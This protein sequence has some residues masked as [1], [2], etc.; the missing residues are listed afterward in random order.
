[1]YVPDFLALGHATRDLAPGGWTLGG[2]V[3]FAAQT[4]YALGKRPAIVTSGDVRDLLGQVPGRMTVKPSRTTVF[5]NV[6]TPEGRRQTLLARAAPLT[7]DDVPLAWRAAPIVVLTPL[8]DELPPSLVNA[9]PDSLVVACLQGWLRAW[10][11]QG[12]VSPRP[13]PASV[14]LEQA[15]AAT[16]S[17]EDLGGDE[18]AAREVA[19]RCR[20]VAVTRGRGGV[21]LFHDGVSISLPALPIAERHPTGAGDVFAAA[22]AIR[23]AETGDPREAA[24]FG[25]AAAAI[26]VAG[27]GL[28]RRAAIAARV[29]EAA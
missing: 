8:C 26:W 9:F 15:A 5:A 6:Y 10:D 4:A 17:I 16:L 14:A 12:H 20:V 24:Q 29:A 18:A 11:E 7:L 23:L 3:V 2:G 27:E 22:F 13:L 25:N 21:T 1:M 19:R 28:P